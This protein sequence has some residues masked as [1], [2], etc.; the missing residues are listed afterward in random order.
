[1][2]DWNDSQW[3]AGK[4]YDATEKGKKRKARYE[5]TDKAKERQRRYE[6]TDEAKEKRR[7]RQR[8]YLLRRKELSE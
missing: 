2:T 3:Q 4:R 1:M 6:L 7:A 5:T 8:L